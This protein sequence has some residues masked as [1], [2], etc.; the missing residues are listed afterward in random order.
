MSPVTHLLIEQIKKQAYHL[1]DAKGIKY[2]KALDQIS[3]EKG[4]R[5]WCD[6]N[7]QQSEFAGRRSAFYIDPVQKWNP[8]LK[9]LGY[10]PSRVFESLS[11][12]YPITNG[13]PEDPTAAPF[14]WGKTLAEAEE[15]AKRANAKRGLSEKEFYEI[16][17]STFEH[18]D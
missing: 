16:L 12:H 3:K 2:Q 1:R 5:S 11:G 15:T 7:E 8:D 4:Y 14:Y 18:N 17:T 9:R 13:Y 6:V 10:T